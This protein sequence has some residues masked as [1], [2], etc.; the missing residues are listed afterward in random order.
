[1]LPRKSRPKVPNQ[2][3]KAALRMLRRIDPHQ[4]YK[5]IP[6]IISLVLSIDPS[7]EVEILDWLEPV[8]GSIPWRSVKCLLTFECAPIGKW[9]VAMLQPTSNSSFD[10]IL[11]VPYASQND[12]FTGFIAAAIYPGDCVCLPTH[13]D[14][15]YTVYE[16]RPEENC[17]LIATADNDAIPNPSK[18]KSE[19]KVW[20]NYMQVNTILFLGCTVKRDVVIGP[21]NEVLND[22]HATDTTTHTLVELEEKVS[23]QRIYFQIPKAD[24][25]NSLKKLSVLSKACG[26][27]A[28]LSD[29]FGGTLT[30]RSSNKS[31]ISNQEPVAPLRRKSKIVQQSVLFR[32]DIEEDEDA[33][34]VRRGPARRDRKDDPV[35][36]FQRKKHVQ[37]WAARKRELSLAAKALSA[38]NPNPLLYTLEDTFNEFGDRTYLVDSLQQSKKRREVWLQVGRALRAI[39]RGGADGHILLTAWKEWT[40]CGRLFRIEIEKKLKMANVAYEDGVKKHAPGITVSPQALETPDP[41][42]CVAAW[43]SQRLP[44]NCDFDCIVQARTYIRRRLYDILKSK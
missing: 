27:T 2:G 35:E 36:S 14:T 41:N 43:Y 42:T 3:I 34:P 7:V 16:I 9:C 12:S 4:G 30:S 33:G 29:Q 1:M 28:S 22:W 40:K 37:V 20:R 23:Y 26:R 6:K 8:L 13:K 44:T 11:R 5:H 24:I 31:N 10:R 19:R 21:L 39:S 15:W 18:V 38:I 25:E 17:V 32:A